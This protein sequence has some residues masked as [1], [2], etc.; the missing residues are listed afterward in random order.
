MNSNLET[1]IRNSVVAGMEVVRSA[2]LAPAQ[3]GAKI[4]RDR[5]IVTST[6]RQAEAAICDCLRDIHGTRFLAEEGTSAGSGALLLLVDPLDGT[7]HFAVRAPTSTVIVAGVNA[8]GRVVHVTIGEPAT[9]RLWQASQR[10]RTRR[11]MASNTKRSASC[12]VWNGPL[13][14]QAVVFVDHSQG[15]KRENGTRRILTDMQVGRLLTAIPQTATLLML[16]SNGLHTAL[17]ANGSEFAAG[18]ITTAIGGAWDI[19]GV[20]LVLQA[21]GAAQG[22]RVTEEGRLAKVD[23]F[24]IMEC[25]IMITGN[26]PKTV[27]TLS[28]IMEACL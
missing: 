15:F 2:Q 28:S 10:Q 18:S 21:G 27:E 12:R 17:V 24:Q 25:D 3:S 4:K 9:G 11:F 19:A 16:G 26:S 22:F 13:T 23:P 8:A 5:S 6:D 7:R 20:L 14:R 1:R